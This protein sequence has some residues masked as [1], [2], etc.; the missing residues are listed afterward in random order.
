L[1]TVYEKETARVVAV[2]RMWAWYE[3]EEEDARNKETD[4]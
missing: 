4:E 1:K 3:K 2:T